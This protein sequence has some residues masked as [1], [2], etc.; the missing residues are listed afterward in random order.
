MKEPETQIIEAKTTSKLQMK[1]IDMIK[2]GYKAEGEMYMDQQTKLMKQK[3]V[4][5]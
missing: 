1:M 2:R 4:K 3:M 5:K